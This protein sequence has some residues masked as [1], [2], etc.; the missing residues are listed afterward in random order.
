M[1]EKKKEA[2]RTIAKNIR[3][4]FLKNW[5]GKCSIC[6][7]SVEKADLLPNGM[8]DSRNGAVIGETIKLVGHRIC[9]EN[10]D[11]IVVKQNRIRIYSLIKELRERFSKALKE[12]KI[13]DQVNQMLD[14]MLEMVRLDPDL[15]PKA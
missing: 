8:P 1:D 7:R 9:M 14:A 11:N 10:V 3:D 12:I 5:D 2:L 15:I 4:E 6:G 13:L